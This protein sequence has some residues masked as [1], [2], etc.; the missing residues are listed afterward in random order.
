MEQRDI[1]SH[2]CHCHDL[3]R[4]LIAQLIAEDGILPDPVLPHHLSGL[5]GEEEGKKEGACREILKI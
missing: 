3:S 2:I 4:R 1:K 5:P